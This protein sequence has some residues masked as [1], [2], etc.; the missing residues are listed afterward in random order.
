MQYFLAVLITYSSFPICA[1][2]SLN[3]III[4]YFDSFSHILSFCFLKKIIFN[5]FVRIQIWCTCHL[6]VLRK[7]LNLLRFGFWPTLA[8]L[9]SK[10]MSSWTAFSDWLMVFLDEAHAW[11]YIHLNSATRFLLTA[12]ELLSYILFSA[13]FKGTVPLHFLES[14]FLLIYPENDLITFPCCFTLLHK[15]PLLTSHGHFSQYNNWLSTHTVNHKKSSDAAIPTAQRTEKKLT[16]N[17]ADI[18]VIGL[19]FRLYTKLFQHW[20]FPGFKSCLGIPDISAARRRTPVTKLGTLVFIVRAH[21]FIIFPMWKQNR[22]RKTVF[23]AIGTKMCRCRRF[24]FNQYEWSWDQF[25][26]GKQFRWA[27]W[28]SLAYRSSRWRGSGGIHLRIYRVV[29]A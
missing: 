2:K 15:N 3:I 25:E 21:F 12:Y 11:H 26:T 13:R 23:W 14:I 6:S 1:L 24:S 27:Q 8:I 29:D 7:C 5:F 19:C 22:K 16:P 18:S 20:I 28:V 9:I 17:A 10:S 4:S